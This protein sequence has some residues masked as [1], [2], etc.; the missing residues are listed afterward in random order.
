[1][2][3]NRHVREARLAGFLAGTPR[4]RRCKFL[5]SKKTTAWAEE[6]LVGRLLALFEMNGVNES[7][8]RPVVA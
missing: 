4:C 7:E 6:F 1:M 8:Y 2:L 5:I 3:D